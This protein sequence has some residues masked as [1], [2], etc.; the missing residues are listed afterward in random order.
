MKCPFLISFDQ[1]KFEV[2]FVWDKYFYSCLFSGTIGLVN[3]PGFHHK[4]VFISV[5]KICLLYTT[6]F[7]ISLF[8]QVCQKVSFDGEVEYLNIQC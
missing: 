7:Q 1:R 8:N 2:Y 3:L 5:N 4:P 6:D